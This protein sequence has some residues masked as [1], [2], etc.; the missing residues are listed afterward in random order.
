M[1]GKSFFL[2]Y[3]LQ[4]NYAFVMKHL[5]LTISLAVLVGC[6]APEVASDAQNEPA[7]VDAETSNTP[8]PIAS[9]DMDYLCT[10]QET[11]TPVCGFQSPEDAEWLP[12][13]SGL[14]VSEYGQYILEGR[15]SL[16][17]HESG[18]ITLLHDASMYDAART[19]DWG[20]T[21]VVQ[22]KKFSPHGISL[23]QRE[24]GRWQ[25]LVVNH[26]ETETIDFFELLQ[27]DGEWKLQWRGGVDSPD[28]TFFNDVA[29][30]GDG[31]FATRF[32]L[33]KRENLAV[34]YIEQRENGIV[35]KWMPS[36]GWSELAG[37][38]GVI[39]NGILWNEAADELVVNEWG[40]SR[41][42]VFSGA[43]EKKYTLEDVKHP[44]NVSWNDAQDGYLIASKSV[45][46]ETLVECGEAGLEVCEGL[47]HIYEITP[48]AGTMTTRY[49]SDGKFWGPPSNAVEKDGKLYIGSFGGTRILVVE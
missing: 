9:A 13:G 14:I 42:N 49:E 12:D 23:S 2:D 16:L 8:E 43:G 11:M 48:E 38:K 39:L 44:D 24:D 45:P 20:E 28:G 34:D 32:F 3:G 37:T 4:Q 47:F 15:I 31:F 35:K 18:E 5:V 17:N 25:L 27:V 33:D 41:V 22:K 19:N 36:E 46:L 40:R 7:P 21:G 30:N 6:G 1:H 29:A 26:A 10:P